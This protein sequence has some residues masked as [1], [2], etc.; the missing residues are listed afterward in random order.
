MLEVLELDRTRDGRNRSDS[1][2]ASA[3]SNGCDTGG[4]EGFHREVVSCN[5][6]QVGGVGNGETRQCR[7]E[8]AKLGEGL[9]E[10]AA[11]DVLRNDLTP[12]GSR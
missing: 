3:S 6:S 12:S 11:I 2:A 5:N 8:F 9:V 10:E 1:T 4:I 7:N